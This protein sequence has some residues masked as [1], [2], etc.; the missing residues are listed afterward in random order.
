MRKTAIIFLSA[1]LLSI[2][3]TSCK[4]D[5]PNSAE[6]QVQP[7]S[8]TIE[9]FGS[10]TEFRDSTN[11]YNWADSDRITIWGGST[12]AGHTFRIS[13]GFGTQNG[14]FSYSESNIEPML[15]APYTAVFPA[16]AWSEIT[17]TAPA[18]SSNG[19]VL[20]LR[21]TQNYVEG[22]SLTPMYAQSEDHT[23]HFKNACG[24]LKISA[25]GSDTTITDITV[26]TDSPICGNFTVTFDGNNPVLTYTNGGGNIIRLH[27]AVP[28][29]IASGKDFYIYLP[30]GSYS[31]VTISLYSNT[32][33]VC[34]YTHTEVL[35]IARSMIS[36]IEIPESS[37]NFVNFSIGEPMSSYFSITPSKKVRFS[38]GNLQFINGRWQFA[39][40]QYD[41]WG[42]FD[43]NAWDLFGW[44]TQNN[45]YGMCPS[46]GYNYGDYA[47]SRV[48]WGRVAG[49]NWRTLNSD[50]WNHLINVRN[51]EL[52]G[53]ATIIANGHE[54]HGLV[55]LPDNWEIN[56]LKYFRTDSTIYVLKDHIA[57]SDTDFVRFDTI[58]FHSVVTS[59]YSINKLSLEIWETM[60]E[61]QGAVFL[62]AAGYR[63][64]ANIHLAN[65]KGNYWSNTEKSNSNYTL[66]FGSGRAYID[67]NQ[68]KN[69][70]RS[71]R[72]VQPVQ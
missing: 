58:K 62:P 67:L 7:F 40:H 25:T 9:G 44:S 21:S 27:C 19:K 4:K 48:D 34:T 1:S 2:G 60:F 69:G 51:K 38:P 70:G 18:W 39:E 30:Q 56:Y 71:V 29:K 50:E 33:R 16:T 26:E 55:L 24:L 59:S 17:Y 31:H 23:L 37:L 35:H 13:S 42:N 57:T 14:E 47:G 72:L 53:V 68:D 46:V 61:S 8:A 28:T 43:A 66:V 65:E 10:K 64:G 20:S 15:A 5:D 63:Y 49:A 45:D 11:A 32:G 12:S 22:E 3:L 6:K 52:R 41:F 54:L 36:S